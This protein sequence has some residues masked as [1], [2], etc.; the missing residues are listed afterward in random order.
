MEDV[1]VQ[2][3]S[4]ADVESLLAMM[5]TFN[6]L[7]TISWSAA[8]ARPALEKLLSSPDL[9]IAG[10]ILEQEDRRGYFVLTWG[11]D[12][13]WSGR[14]AF[15]TELYLVAGARGRGIGRD[16]L[17]QIEIFASERGARAIHLMVRPDNERAVRLYGGAGFTSPPRIFLTKEL[18]H[19]R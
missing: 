7:E 10:W 17:A 13:E 12:L 19:S 15:L 6:A 1:H 9:G 11:F 18:A 16:A 8:S 4:L 2:P 14:D 3:A 5:L